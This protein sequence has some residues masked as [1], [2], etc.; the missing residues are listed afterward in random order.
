MA[1]RNHHFI[2]SGLRVFAGGG[3]CGK[4]NGKVHCRAWQWGK[5]LSHIE[6][7]LLRRFSGLKI[8]AW[9]IALGAA[10]VLPLQLYIIFGPADGPIRL[11]WVYW[12]WRHYP[13]LALV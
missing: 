1:A 3:G 13:S 10:C 11:V 12:R 8:V 9:S 2:G 5:V 4:S 7:A 6:E